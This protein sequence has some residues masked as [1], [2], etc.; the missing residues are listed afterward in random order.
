MYN[1]AA[2]SSKTVYIP[3]NSAVIYVIKWKNANESVE[4]RKFL[5]NLLNKKGTGIFH[6]VPFPMGRI[7]CRRGS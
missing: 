1:V 4:I 2:S 5:V 3:I 6:P 7:I